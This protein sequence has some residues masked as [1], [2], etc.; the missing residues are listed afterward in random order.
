MI[1]LLNSGMTALTTS[2]APS[3]ARAT[4][5]VSAALRNMAVAL[6]LPTCPATKAARR[7]S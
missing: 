7:S 2:F 5:S 4:A 3:P 6:P 1:D